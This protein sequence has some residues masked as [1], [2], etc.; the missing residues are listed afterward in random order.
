MR[1]V[2]THTE[3]K[4][5]VRSPFGSKVFFYTY[6]TCMDRRLR[7]RP[8]DLKNFGLGLKKI[9]EFNFFAHSP[10]S[11]KIFNAVTHIA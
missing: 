9:A 4:Y 8:K 10:A 7:N 2:L 11:L 5:R 3:V 6:Q 1:Q